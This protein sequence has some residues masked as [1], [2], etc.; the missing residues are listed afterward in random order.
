[1]EEKLDKAIEVV[2]GMVRT[3]LKPDEALKVTQAALNLA[4]VKA[5]FAA[6]NRG[7]KKTGAGAS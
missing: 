4:H 3:N 6:L 2:L 5:Q 7:G 1:M